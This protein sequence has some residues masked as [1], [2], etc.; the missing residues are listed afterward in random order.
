MSKLIH[1]KY[2][3][4]FML[5]LLGLAI[6][7]IFIWHPSQVVFDEF[8]F[9][10]F[11]NG[12]FNGEYFFDIHP[13]L[14]KL[15]IALG[16]YLG[17]YQAEF[18]FN[19][20]GEEFTNNTFIALRFF[21]AILGAFLP[22]SVYFL[23]RSLKGSSIAAF[24]A[25]L[26]IVFENALITQSRFMLLDS[27][28]LFF[29]FTGLALFFYYRNHQKPYTYLIASGVLMVMALAVKWTGLSF[30]ALAWLL[31]PWDIYKHKFFWKEIKRRAAALFLIPLAVYL[32]IFFIHF[33]MLPKSGQ[34]DAFM[35]ERF[36]RSIEG[37]RTFENESINPYN[38]FQDFGELHG[39]MFLR[40]AELK[41][42]HAYSSSFY[43]WPVM[44]RTIYY[45]IQTHDDGNHERIYLMGN[46]SIWWA[47][48]AFLI[49][50][51]FLWKPIT[52][53]EIKWILFIGWF[54]NVLP[55]LTV[56]RVLFLYHYF[57]ALI[58]SIIIMSVFIS[59]TL[60]SRKN[61]RLIVLSS[62]LVVFICCYIFFS[63]LTYGLPLSDEQFE[64]R[65]W[66][67]GWN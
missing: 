40:N 18:G 6:R 60:E 24:F 59:D 22:M 4:P 34:G 15:L 51:L 11:V 52:S 56:S 36:L 55:F 37:S 19:A 25:G 43:S 1:E 62:L 49:V 26:V 63:P 5:G 39:V 30:I 41:K 16:G 2:I 17:G 44:S 20:I 64:L 47:A 50:A 21:P 35:S 45:W 66:L 10:K 28:L 65:K 33:A 12:Y 61:M 46:P 9:G 23:T 8:H 38:F 42:T 48:F 58:F 14:G 29:G 53:Y 13:P 54:V 31:S 32:M 27:M 57:T 3:L 67:K 7:F